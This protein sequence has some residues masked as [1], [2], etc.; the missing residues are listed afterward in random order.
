MVSKP[1]GK[2][3]IA[4]GPIP[5]R[6]FGKSLGINNIPPH[7]CSFCC[8]YC[9]VG[10]VTRMAIERE[11]FYP[12][13]TIFS[14][15]KAHLEAV[16][17]K[18]EKVDF[19]S[20]V[21]DG[22]P[23]LDKNLGEA[24]SLLKSLNIKIAVVTNATLLWDASVRQDIAS[25]DWVSIKVDAVLEEPWRKLN[26]PHGGLELKNILDGILKFGKEY[27]GRLTT[28]TLLVDGINDKPE[29]L[30]AVAEFLK[31]L[32]PETAYLA[33]PT[34]PPAER[35]IQSAKK[36]AVES[37]VK[38]FQSNYLKVVFLFDENTEGFGHS[39]SLA[40]DILGITSVH[41]MAEEALRDFVKEAKANWSLVE[42]LI[43]QKKLQADEFEGKKFYKAFRPK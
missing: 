21:P 11:N 8:V 39:G 25:A 29:S 42:D 13:A 34:R 31:R 33:L 19:L 23:T 32:K 40:E 26:R 37:A 17:A 28:E 6:R 15:V 27:S 10:R 16:R 38:I 30:R 43:S 1:L 18:G 5:S 24:I 9:Q 3:Q 35:K 36:S 4:F 20:F 7:I 2:A 22:E 14:E 12:P 41:P